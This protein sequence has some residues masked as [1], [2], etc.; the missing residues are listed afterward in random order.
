MNTELPLVSVCIPT[1]N[2]AERLRRAVTRLLGGD[3]PALE[4]IISD[5]GS[6]DHTE[7]VAA[8][9]R[10]DCTRLRY[11]RQPGNLGPTKNFEFARSQAR[12]RYFLWLGDDDYLAGDFIGLCVQ[13]LER[14]PSLALAAGV[15][16]YHGGDQVVTRFG[17]VIDAGSRHSLVRV[18]KYLFLVEDNSIF[19]GV[20]R[21]EAVAHCTLPNFLAGDWAWLAEVLREGRARI[22]PLAYAFREESESNTSRSL[23]KIV[24][25]LG[26]PAWHARHPW[27]AIPLNLAN[28]LAFASATSRGK[29]FAAKAAWWLAVFATVFSRQVLIRVGPRIP[30]ARWLRRFVRRTGMPQPGG[31]LDGR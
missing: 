28:H 25:V 16:A 21:R 14:D 11:F 15:A 30:F 10:R 29:P 18:L 31:P 20:Y 7:Q 24:A 4:I 2:R 5:N 12:G 13:Q 8:E 3:Y 9:L 26:L 6:S 23:E 17:N 19:C 27:I 1:Y 22:L